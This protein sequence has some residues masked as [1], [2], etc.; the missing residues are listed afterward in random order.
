MALKPIE[1]WTNYGLYGCMIAACGSLSLFLGIVTSLSNNVLMLAM[2]LGYNPTSSF[3][4]A[5]GH[6]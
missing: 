4:F 2:F 1:L 6:R 5:S 3:C